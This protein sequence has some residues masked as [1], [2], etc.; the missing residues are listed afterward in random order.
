CWP[1]ATTGCST[2]RPC[3]WRWPPRSRTSTRASCSAGSPS[4]SPAS[5]SS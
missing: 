2:C 1:R 5:R 3:C 4:T